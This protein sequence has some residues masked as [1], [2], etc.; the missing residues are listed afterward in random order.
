[1]ADLK[2]P[3]TGGH[4][5]WFMFA[6]HDHKELQSY[7]D[8]IAK[9]HQLARFD[10]HATLIGLLDF[11]KTRVPFIDQSTAELARQF[12]KFNLELTGIGMRDVHFQSVFL[13]AV[14]HSTFVQ[15]NQAAR[16]LFSHQGDPPLMPHASLVYSDMPSTAKRDA[17]A[18]KLSA[19]IT[20]PWSLLVTDIAIADVSGHPNEWQIISRYPLL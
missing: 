18:S 19:T 12:T 4:A 10:A 3:L 13:A 1:M 6:P 11:D 16:E 5:L 9:E 17:I 15:A 20:F 14:P 2:P 8:W 7:I